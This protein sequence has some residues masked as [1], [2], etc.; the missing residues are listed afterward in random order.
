VTQSADE[1]EPSEETAAAPGVYEDG[2]LCGQ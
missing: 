1:A 2:V